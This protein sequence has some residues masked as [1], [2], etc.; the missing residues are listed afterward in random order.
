MLIRIKI[1]LFRK[2]KICIFEK[3]LFIIYK[4]MKHHDKVF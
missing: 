2:T 3:Y 1:V 4:T